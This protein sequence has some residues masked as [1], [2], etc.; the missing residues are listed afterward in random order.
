MAGFPSSTL[1]TDTEAPYTATF[2]TT[3]VANTGVNAGNIQAVARD[4]AG[5]TR[6]VGNAITIDNTSPSR[7][8]FESDRAGNS[9]IYSM[10]PAGTGVARLTNSAAADSRPSLS[11]DGNLIAWES[12]GQV[13]VMAS[14]GSNKRPLTSNGTS[15]APAFSPTGTKIAFQ[16][17]RGAGMD[18]WVM[19]AGGTGQTPLTNAPGADV[20]PGWSP[21][22]TRLALR[23]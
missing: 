12:A 10:S 18:I 1:G 9:E 19:N 6:T 4:A 7:I 23:L 17:D 3:Q 22:G 8:V 13:W 15:G 14:D 2:D 16:S 21:D 20:N 11:P 5:N